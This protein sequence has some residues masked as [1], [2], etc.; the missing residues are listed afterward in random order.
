MS[1]HE[2]YS[3]LL[4]EILYVKSLLIGGIFYKLPVDMFLDGRL[5]VLTKFLE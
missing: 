5:L 3:F 2:K 1:K 4:S